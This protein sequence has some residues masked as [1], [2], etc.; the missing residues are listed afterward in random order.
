MQI[1]DVEQRLAF[2]DTEHRRE[3]ADLDRLRGQA[4]S[5]AH[6]LDALA[7][8]F[9]E[10]TTEVQA[11]QARLAEMETF[12]DSLTNLRAELLGLIEAEGQRTRVSLERLQGDDSAAALRDEDLGQR[13]QGLRVD[14]DRAVLDV[15]DLRKSDTG[16]QAGLTALGQ[17]VQSLRADVDRAVLDV[18]D[19]RKSDTGQAANLTALAKQV[20]T[21]TDAALSLARQTQTLGA[22]DT[23]HSERLTALADQVQ[24]LFDDVQATQS[25]VEGL[26][27]RIE[28][29]TTETANLYR[30]VQG[31]EERLTAA[32]A[33]TTEVRDRL[34]RQGDAMVEVGR[35]LQSL[36]ADLSATQSQLIKF[37]Q[38]EQALE[39]AKTELTQL[40][41]D[42]RAQ[43]QAD[44]ERALRERLEDRQHTSQALAVLQKGLEPIPPIQDRLA[45]NEREA[46]RLNGLLAQL[47]ARL[48]DLA[49]EMGQRV[50]PIPFL[51]E[52]LQKHDLRLGLVEH[53]VATVDRKLD[54]RVAPIPFLD[55]GLLAVTKRVDVV[56]A[57]QPGYTL[58]LDEHQGRIQ[59]LDER[60]NTHVDRLDQLESRLPG[61]VRAD[62]ELLEKVE[63]LEEWIQRTA[64]RLDEVQRFEDDLRRTLAEVVEAEK[65]R[66]TH[67]EQ[68]MAAWAEEL[69]AHRKQMEVWQKVLRGYE[70]HHL[71]VN[72]QMVALQDQATQMDQ[73]QRAS[74]EAHRIEAEKI[75]REVSEWQGDVD[76]RW[77]LFF[78]QRDWDWKE[79]KA[80]NEA[81]AQF[82][83]RLEAWRSTDVQT[84]TE[85][86]G[87]LDIKDRELLMRIEDLWEVEE[88]A[89]QRRLA[90]LK[91]W[92]GEVQESKSKT[93]KPRVPKPGEK[94][95][96]TDPRYRRP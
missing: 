8:R 33:L 55:Q 64:T 70:E 27:P 80:V 19:L 86:A 11:T 83:A 71:G 30:L 40:I 82:L 1:S 81:H 36:R 75:R 46:S 95:V 37:P 63:F 7:R 69:V 59:F 57:M 48:G 43:N 67:R 62:T 92:L 65:V 53:D 78:K 44:L 15:T 87:R 28:T 76:K 54:A 2:L 18:T 68:R 17:H 42:Y 41:R 73:Q 23:Q 38:I 13:V 77:A 93:P 3:R 20:Q 26:Q 39:Q 10:L 49:R 61:F 16:H 74:L 90:D 5:Q 12:Q 94:V 79:Q 50:D 52:Q 4:Q 45:Q 22:A 56:E 24:A 35:A 6:S 32:H 96:G 21:A 34:D 58:R 14:V 85:L 66:D 29:H 9:V 25:R 84:T 47:D 60:D 91:E 89:L 88:A 51:D 72:R 31:L